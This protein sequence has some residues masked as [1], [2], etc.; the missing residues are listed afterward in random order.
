VAAPVRWNISFLAP[1]RFH[2]GACKRWQQITHQSSIRPSSTEAA[3]NPQS[4]AAFSSQRSSQQHPPPKPLRRQI[5][6][7][8]Q[9][10][11]RIPARSFLRLSDAGPYTGSPARAGPASETLHDSGHSLKWAFADKGTFEF[12][13]RHR[14]AAFGGASDAMLVRPRPLAIK[15]SIRNHWTSR[16]CNW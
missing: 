15:L 4:S 13:G 12:W 2:P 10:A 6:I 14:R 5:P 1:R 3:P 7:D 11:H 9:S 8:G 16:G